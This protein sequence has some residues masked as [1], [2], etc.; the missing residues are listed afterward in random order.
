[1]ELSDLG[2]VRDNNDVHMY[3]ES[4]GLKP[5]YKVLIELL[6]VFRLIK[7]FTVTKSYSQTAAIWPCRK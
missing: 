5:W 2:L 7:K 3:D 4:F 1:L 6:I